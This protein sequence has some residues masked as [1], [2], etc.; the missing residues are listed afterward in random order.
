MTENLQGGDLL[1]QNLADKRGGGATGNLQGHDLT[2][3]DQVMEIVITANEDIYFNYKQW[4]NTG[5]LHDDCQFYMPGFWYRRNLRSPKEAPS[6]H[7][8]DSWTVREDRLSVP[9]T[10]F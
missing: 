7:T 3:A 6:F 1:Q 9:M 2:A 5:Y 4:I 8:S 10:R